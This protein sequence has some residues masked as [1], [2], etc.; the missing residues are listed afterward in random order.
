MLSDAIEKAQELILRVETECNRVGLGLNGPKTKYLTYNIDDHPHSP[1]TLLL[2]HEMAPPSK[3]RRTSST[4]V[5]ESLKDIRVRK[6][7]AWQ[8]LNDMDKVC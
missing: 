3:K 4:W 8:A 6:G 2:L 7:L 1:D 5:D